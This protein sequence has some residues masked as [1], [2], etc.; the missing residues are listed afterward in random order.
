MPSLMPVLSLACTLTVA[1]IVAN[2]ELQRANDPVKDVAVTTPTDES[3]EAIFAQV[4]TKGPQTELRDM[5]IDALTIVTQGAVTSAE[6]DLA[7][8]RWHDRLAAGKR[9]QVRGRSAGTTSKAALK[10][11]K[12]Q[13]DKRRSLQKKRR[14][15]QLKKARHAVSRAKKLRK[16][17]E[18]RRNRGKFERSGAYKRFGSSYPLT[19][20]NRNI[21]RTNTRRPK[22]SRR[23]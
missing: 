22:K 21:R 2:H 3:T 20:A 14:T 9:S 7:K 10:K 13:D 1:G 6:V 4:F 12:K 5:N 23:R 17:K 11:I 16:V 8:Q 19:N 18:E 15:E